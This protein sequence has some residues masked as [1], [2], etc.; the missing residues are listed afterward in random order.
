MRH[1][2]LS[3]VAQQL[4]PPPGCTAEVQRVKGTAGCGAVI[5]G[6]N[7]NQVSKC[8]ITTKRMVIVC[9]IMGTYMMV[10]FW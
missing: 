2:S 6:Y 1:S 9:Y 8:L 5:N 3:D 7:R 10:I 4:L